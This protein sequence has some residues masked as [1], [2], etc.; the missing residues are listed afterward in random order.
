MEYDYHEAMK[1]GHQLCFPLYAAARNVTGLY[2]PLLKPLGLTYTQYIVFLVLWEKDG[3]SVTEIGEKLMLDNGTL[4][5]LLKKMEQ[6]GYVERR[7][8]REDDRVVEITLT[9]KGRALQEDA[10]DIPLKAAGC[11]DLAPE[12]AQQLYAL[13]YELL[14]NQGYKITHMKGAKQ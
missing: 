13:L 9:E 4:S 1:L 8:C 12:K 6:A 7:R 11:I 3:V 2:T 14:E 5:P 10:K